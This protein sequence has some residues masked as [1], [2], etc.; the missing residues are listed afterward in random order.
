MIFKYDITSI[1]SYVLTTFIIH[2]KTVQSWPE[3][4][5]NTQYFER[6]CYHLNNPH[7]CLYTLANTL[8]QFSD[9]WI[10]LFKILWDQTKKW[11]H[12]SYNIKYLFFVKYYVHIYERKFNICHLR[13][14]VHK[15]YENFMQF[16]DFKS[17]HVIIIVC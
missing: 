17:K 14:V 5:K 8:C 9:I 13:W 6:K 16:S 15:I 4:Y 12:F 3:F 11:K 7:I 1:L 10:T 2:I